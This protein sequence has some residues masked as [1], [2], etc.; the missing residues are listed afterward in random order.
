MLQKP[1][2]WTKYRCSYNSMT[3]NRLYLVL[4]LALLAGYGYLFWMLSIHAQHHSFS[5]CLFK[6]V[7]GIACPSC[8]VTRSVLLLLHGN[9]KQ[10]TLLNP[11]GLIT[12][13]LMAVMP[14]WLLYDMLLN[15]SSLHLT[16]RKTEALLRKK[17]VAI[18]LIILILINWFWNIHKGL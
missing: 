12:G 10:A 5:P 4:F 6:N 14:F 13:L 3:R 8:G 7:T 11:L 18:P 15:K 2:I 1:R 9:I 17:Q 16:F